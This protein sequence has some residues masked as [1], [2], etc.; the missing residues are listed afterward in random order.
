MRLWWVLLTGLLTGVAGQ[1]LQQQTVQGPRSST[2]TVIHLVKTPYQEVLS[3]RAHED[4]M[5]DGSRIES[6]DTMHEDASH[7]V[8]EGIEVT[9]HL[10]CTIA[11]IT[12]IRS[13]R[14]NRSLSRSASPHYHTTIASPFTRLVTPILRSHLFLLQP[15]NYMLIN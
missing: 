12:T 14:T 3:R 6:I 11:L 7:K 8:F 2:S 10:R 13:I 15:P 9:H 4:R 1:S 5:D